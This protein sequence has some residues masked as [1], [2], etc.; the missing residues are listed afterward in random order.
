[1]EEKLFIPD[2]GKGC[3]LHALGSVERIEDQHHEG[4]K[5]KHNGNDEYG[6]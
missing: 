4:K 2:K 3:P 6:L 1:M 5:K